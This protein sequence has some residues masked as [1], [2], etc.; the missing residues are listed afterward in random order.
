ML[1]YNVTITIDLPSA[2]EW[3][4]WMRDEHIPDVMS[5]GMFISYRLSRL[6]DHEHSDSEIY[7]VQYLVRDRASWLRYF[8]EFQPALQQAHRTR[9]AGRFAAFRTLMEVVDHNEKL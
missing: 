8:E 9:Y 7:T 3:L 6:L 5:T 1:L 2:A 4:A